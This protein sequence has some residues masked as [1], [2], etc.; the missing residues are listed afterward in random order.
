MERTRL[1]K[2]EIEKKPDGKPAFSYFRFYK[3]Y[4]GDT[5]DVPRLRAESVA[6]LLENVPPHIYENDLI[7]GSVRGVLASPD[8]SVSGACEE[9]CGKI[10]ERTFLTGV[11]HFAPHYRMML[12]RGIPGIFADLDASER[13]HASDANRV[14]YIGEMRRVWT[15]FSE[16]VR[17]YAEK[18]ESLIDTAGYDEGRLRAIASRC[19]ALLEHA[20]EHFDEA[21]QFVWFCHIAFQLEG[22]YAMALGRIDRYLLPFYLKD[23]EEGNLTSDGAREMLENVF[24]KIY[25]RRAFFGGD[26]VVNICIG[27]TA[28]DGSCDVNPLS[29]DVLHA[30]GGCGIPGPNLS[31]RMMKDT[32]VEFYDECLKVIGT[33]L[34]YPAMMNDE[35]NLP[36]LLSYGYDEEDV[37]DYCMVGCIETVLPGKQW[38]WGDG[39]FGTPRFLEPIFNHGH[40]IMS[41]GFNVDTGDVSDIVSMEDFMKKFEIQLAS[42]VEYYVKHTCERSVCENE[43]DKTSPMLSLCCPECIER[44]IDINLGGTKYPSSHGVCLMGVG[45]TADSLAAIEKTVFVDHTL[46][47]SQIGEAIK[48]DFV[49]MEDVRALLKSAPKYGNNDDFA[50]K[51]AVWFVDFLTREFR[52]YHMPDGGN[53]YT[54][55]AANT[56][57]IYSGLGTAATPDGRRAGEP[58]SDAASPTYGVD[59]NGVT[60][61]VL[62]LTKPDYSVVACG[63]VVN[64]KFMPDAFADGNREKLASLLRVY[65]ARGGQE[66][67]INATSPE[68]LTDAMEH[69]EKYGSLVVRVSGF[70]AH[71]V[72]LDR[73]IQND[74]LH[75]TQQRI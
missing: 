68:V 6:S 24:M 51:Y 7:V 53:F 52:K 31:A 26:D 62:S 38:P 67:Q 14:K 34:G 4:D 57:N 40:G 23:T 5:A 36:A 18:A 25:E 69:P 46:T 19:R 11:D 55:M 10:G 22:R 35:V 3:L 1:L 72:T 56:A 73:R 54:A 75:R 39:R 50:D 45:T 59:V 41:D 27:G 47:L 44:G 66:M 13:A 61:T 17:S 21:L 29:Y 12:S 33:G 60:S 63:S 16:M 64:Q 8:D 2:K 48:A 30:V 15:G 42:G 37:A 71:Y 70:S 65:F 32:P 58:L 20:P 9:L 28:L 49:G 43:A 74:I